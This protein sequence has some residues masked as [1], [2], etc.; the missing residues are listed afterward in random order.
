MKKK[1]T[2]AKPPQSYIDIWKKAWYTTKMTFDD[3]Q[4]AA[5]HVR[6]FR[7][8]LEIGPKSICLPSGKR[9]IINTA[10]DWRIEE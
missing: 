6:L 2:E 10:D 8:Q 9:L 3:R 7:Q 4:A 1:P 5:G